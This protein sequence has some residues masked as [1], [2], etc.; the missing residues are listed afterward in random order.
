MVN[1]PVERE[2]SDHTYWKYP[3]KVDMEAV[4]A[5]MD[6]LAEALSKEGVPCWAGYTKVPMYMYD[7]FTKPYT[8]GTSGYPLTGS[9]RTYGEGLCPASEKDLKEMIV[10][11]FCEG[12]RPEHIQQIAHAV[13]KVFEHFRKN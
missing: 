1:V 3:L 10:F 9:G 8:Y 6:T 12:Y 11:P 2:W 5:D 7:V 4:T 13:T